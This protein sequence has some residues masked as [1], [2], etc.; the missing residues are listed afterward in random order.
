MVIL[1]FSASAWTKAKASSWWGVIEGMLE[2]RGCA[3]LPSSALGAKLKIMRES[4]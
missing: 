2:G 4:S 3:L 1:C